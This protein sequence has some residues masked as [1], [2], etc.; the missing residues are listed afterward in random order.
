MDNAVDHTRDYRRMACQQV[1]GA[2]RDGVEYRL[3][4]G[5][6][7]GDHSQN[8]GGGR[9]PIQCLLSFV[10]Q[11]GVFY[12]D[13]RL[14]RKCLDQFDLFLS[15]WPTLPTLQCEDAYGSTFS[16]QWHTK[17]AANGDN[18]GVILD[19]V[20]V[21]I[22]ISQKVRNMNRAPLKD[23]T[24]EDRA[25]IGLHRITSEIFAF[26]LSEAK[27]RGDRIFVSLAATDD[28]SVRIAQ[29]HRRLNQCL[30]HTLQVEG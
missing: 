29:P 23:R 11:P 3:H 19:P 4:V 30:K 2:L 27:S 8:V 18:S 1:L 22:A 25:T 28:F 24:S 17:P 15:K 20:S 6:R 21:K 5:W 12:G 10:E 9:L 14:V 7:T 16:Q 13:N 26:L